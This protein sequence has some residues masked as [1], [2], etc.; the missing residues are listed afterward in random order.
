MS[1]KP[2]GCGAVSGARS[3]GELVLRDPASEPRRTSSSPKLF[4]WQNSCVQTKARDDAET[5]QNLLHQ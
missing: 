5:L 2:P 1:L 4:A 3:P